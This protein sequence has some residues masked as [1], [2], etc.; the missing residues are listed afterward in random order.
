MEQ[1]AYW[2]AVA[3]DGSQNILLR[4]STRGEECR[5]SRAV[6]DALMSEFPDVQTEIITVTAIIESSGRD[7]PNLSIS[8]ESDTLWAADLD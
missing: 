5:S 2:I 3:Y 1:V 4:F 8:H 6:L 7:Q